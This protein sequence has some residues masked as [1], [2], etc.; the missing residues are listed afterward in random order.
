[1]MRISFIARYDENI[2]TLTDLNNTN[3]NPE[4]H[5]IEF[6]RK[7]SDYDMG[8]R[9]S[10]SKLPAEDLDFLVVN[11]RWVSERRMNKTLSHC[12]NC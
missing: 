11:T 3:P 7:I 4:L 8:G 6:V 9:Q 1:M 5:L 10:R 2:S 12:Y